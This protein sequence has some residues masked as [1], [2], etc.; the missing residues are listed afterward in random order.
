MSKRMLQQRYPKGKTVAQPAPTQPA[1]GVMPQWQGGTAAFQ[2]TPAHGGPSAF[3][4]AQSQQQENSQDPASMAAPAH[5]WSWGGGEAAAPTP[6]W[7]PQQPSADGY[8][9]GDY[10]SGNYAPQSYPSD[11][12]P[13]ESYPPGTYPSEACPPGGYPSGNYSATGYC[14]EGYP[15]GDF[16]SGDYA[17]LA[18]TSAAQFPAAVVAPQTA[19]GNLSFAQPDQ[20]PQEGWVAPQWG[21]TQWGAGVMDPTAQASL[22]AQPWAAQ[23]WD[24]TALQQGQ[25]WSSAPDGQWQQSGAVQQSSQEQL[26]AVQATPSY[27]SS[28]EAL[29]EHETGHDGSGGSAEQQAFTPVEQPMAPSEAAALADRGHPSG[30]DASERSGEDS[31][32]EERT[33]DGGTMSMFFQDSDDTIGCPAVGTSAENVAPPGSS[34]ADHSQ[35]ETHFEHLQADGGYNRLQV[36]GHCEA[37]ASTE[38]ATGSQASPSV[39]E[40]VNQEVP[41]PVP[42][43][44]QQEASQEV[45]FDM[46]N[47]E[48][49]ELAQ[50]P[51]A[52]KKAVIKARQGSPFRPPVARQG[53]DKALLQHNA[54]QLHLPPPSRLSEDPESVLQPENLELPPDAEERHASLR[55]P[56]LRAAP[57]LAPEEALGVARGLALT[58]LD[59]PEM[60]RLVTLAPAAP[61]VERPSSSA[62]GSGAPACQEPAEDCRAPLEGE[63][64]PPA[65]RVQPQGERGASV[66]MTRQSPLGGEEADGRQP[67]PAQDR[68]HATLAASPPLVDSALPERTEPSGSTDRDAQVMPM[69]T[70]SSQS[71]TSGVRPNATSTPTNRADPSTS[72]QSHT[73]SRSHMDDSSRHEEPRRSMDGAR[74]SRDAREARDALDVRD[75]REARDVRDGRE[76]RDGRETRDVRGAREA[77]ENRDVRD[78]RDGRD[79]GRDDGKEDRADDWRRDDRKKEWRD[80]R[81]ER[82]LSDRDDSDDDRKRGGW[83]RRGVRRDDRRSDRRDDRRDDR[84]GIDRRDDRRDNRRDDSRDDDRRY[85]S[86][87]GR[88]DPRNDLWRNDGP[89]RKPDRHWES[90]RQRGDYRY[91]DRYGDRYGDR[92]RPSSRS[93]VD[94]HAEAS[95]SRRSDRRRHPKDGAPERVPSRH[96][97]SDGS[98]PESRRG[99]H[100]RHRDREDEFV[101]PYY[102]AQ[103]KA[104]GTDAY[105]YSAYRRDYYNYYQY[106]YAPRSGYGYGYYDELYR[107]NPAYKQQV[108][109]RYREYYARLGYDP[110]YLDRLSVHSGRSSANEDSRRDE[111]FCSNTEDDCDPSILDGYTEST[112][113]HEGSFV[114]EV[115]KFSRPHPVARFSGCNGLL[116]LVPST[117]T[118]LPPPVELHDL[119][120]R[121]TVRVQHLQKTFSFPHPWVPSEISYHLSNAIIFC[122]ISNSNDERLCSLKKK[123]GE[124]ARAQLEYNTFIRSTALLEYTVADQYFGLDGDRANV[125]IITQ[126]EKMKSAKKCL[127]WH[128][129]YQ[130]ARETGR[131][132]AG[133]CFASVRSDRFAFQRESLSAWVSS[134]LDGRTM[135]GA[136]SSERHAHLEVRRRTTS[137]LPDVDK[138]DATTRPEGTRTSKYG[139][140]QR[141]RSR[142][143]TNT[144]PQPDQ[145]ARALRSTA[146]DNVVA[147]GLCTNGSGTV[148]LSAGMHVKSYGCNFNLFRFLGRF[149]G[150]RHNYYI[151]YFLLHLTHWQLQV[152]TVQPTRGTTRQLCSQTITPTR[153]LLPTPRAQMQQV[154]P[155]NNSV[156][157]P[158]CH[159]CRC[160][161]CGS[162]R[163]D[164]SGSL[165]CANSDLSNQIE[166]EWNNFRIRRQKYEHCASLPTIAGFW[167]NTLLMKHRNHRWGKVNTKYIG[168]MGNARNAKMLN[169]SSHSIT[170]STKI[171]RRKKNCWAGKQLKIIFNC[172]CYTRPISSAILRIT[173]LADGSSQQ[174]QQQSTFSAQGPPPTSSWNSG[175]QPQAGTDYGYGSNGAAS[176]AHQQPLMN[177]TAPQFAEAPGSPA[178]VAGTTSFDYYQASMHSETH[179][180]QARQ[181]SRERLSSISSSAD[182]RDSRRDSVESSGFMGRPRMPSGPRA[183][184]QTETSGSESERTRS[185]GSKPKPPVAG[186]S[187]LGG[188]FGKLL[189]KASNQMILPD[190]KD[191]DIVWDDQKKCWVDKNAGPGEAENKVVAP[192]SDDA[193]G[194]KVAPMASKPG[195]NRFQMNKQRAFRNNYV[196]ILNPG[197]GA[198]T[199]KEGTFPAQIAPA[200]PES[201]S[202][203][204]QG[205]P[206]QFFVPQLPGEYGSTSQGFDFVSP[207]PPPAMSDGNMGPP[208]PPPESNA[209]YGSAKQPVSTPM[210]FD[211]AEFASRSSDS[212]TSH[213]VPGGLGRRKA[214]PT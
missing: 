183:S 47:R 165:G 2:A 114:H 14:P 84:R 48:G 62:S 166:Y 71:L 100:R 21:D 192:P 45:A 27:A 149:L 77:R 181:A 85:D 15:T 70:P 204:S 73:P 20:A 97:E 164:Q 55:H 25:Q 43:L 102:A 101:A 52:A 108:D 18:P 99:R 92:G 94:G 206:P 136:S 93:S 127:Y 163:N 194:G 154:L 213:H 210:M 189:P 38:G 90:G 106:G 63:G 131:W 214:Y 211:P 13:L 205:P 64:S 172:F 123:I 190:D 12:Y 120:V 209:P 159:C 212:G 95:D 197:G 91:E 193:L 88:R 3:P 130:V 180:Q 207:P 107:T 200:V 86:R 96:S 103:Q 83:D 161:R 151:I 191:P 32:R 111:S 40:P 179:K 152:L 185:A 5:P 186:K 147:P 167:R 50:S 139:G 133:R 59:A 137:S 195:Q 173:P 129:T 144:T 19:M 187:W 46:P 42:V 98:S 7:P 57:L 202:A 174:Q 132:F 33:V 67:P 169:V 68:V 158:S 141:R 188:I 82:S 160:G 122:G 113:L 78:G 41:E 176:N 44:S 53:S 66:P 155:Q 26:D 24:G 51:S 11:G 89:D 115:K 203:S 74:E 76:A 35:S 112:R 60:P 146:A 17:S 199:T 58:L 116:K 138:H 87:D 135:A 177:G 142:T 10:S 145:K 22:Q 65:E 175:A 125:R 8:P 23:Q 196:D 29:P 128:F 54:A 118:N 184:L 117:S 170:N 134:A 110:A 201:P 124:A 121:Y 198:R 171:V 162:L 49:A 4:E 37:L 31:A 105:D 119:K 28:A 6:S 36:E 148:L 1:E 143:L 81:D 153:T 140:G 182:P 34:H 156:S 72:S 69:I 126:S 109:E 61:P 178:S 104:Y 157:E 79:S 80:S 168:K 16:Q 56:K 75:V 208:A 30:M 9:S 150:L 39:E